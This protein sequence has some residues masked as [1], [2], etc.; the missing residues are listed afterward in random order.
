VGAGVKAGAGSALA[1]PSGPPAAPAALVLLAQLPGSC[2][3]AAHLLVH[4]QRW[5]VEHGCPPQAH[6]RVVNAHTVTIAYNLHSVQGSSCC[7]WE[8]E[9]TVCKWPFDSRPLQSCA[10]E[11]TRG[12]LAMV[13]VGRIGHARQAGWQRSRAGWCAG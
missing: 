5:F 4:I 1:A 7:V 13:E 3:A 10:G 8:E 2:A 12:M 9:P 11:G 6:M